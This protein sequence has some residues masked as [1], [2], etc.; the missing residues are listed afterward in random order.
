M[1][2]VTMATA[3]LSTT[4]LNS[5]NNAILSAIDRIRHILKQHGDINWVLNEIKKVMNLKA[6]LENTC[7]TI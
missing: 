2:N 7:R 6:S 5:F 4:E 1:G 3:S